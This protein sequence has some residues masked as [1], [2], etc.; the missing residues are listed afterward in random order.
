LIILPKVNCSGCRKESRVIRTKKD[1][2]TIIPL[3]SPLDPAELAPIIPPKKVLKTTAARA[4][5]DKYSSEIGVKWK[6]NDII[7]ERTNAVIMDTNKPDING[8]LKILFI[9]N[10]SL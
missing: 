4:V 6:I 5:M 9:K 1:N 3:T 2:P 7:I 8:F 10:T